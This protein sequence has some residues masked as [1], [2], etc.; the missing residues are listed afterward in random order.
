MAKPALTHHQYVSFL[1]EFSP[2]SYFNH[3]T[4]PVFRI[5][6]A[7]CSQLSSYLVRG[8]ASK[9]RDLQS[10]HRAP[11]S[12]RT[13]ACRTLIRHPKRLV[14]STHSCIAAITHHG[15]LPRV[16]TADLCNGWQP[17]AHNILA[18]SV[19]GQKPLSSIS[20]NIQ[21]FRS[22]G[23]HTKVTKAAIDA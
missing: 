15:V 16:L 3:H 7:T 4:I 11:T 14:C 6:E 17:E 2:P 23:V 9:S 8:N 22:P 1:G 19:T 5:T 21:A 12:N 18:V 13:P 20:D 10:V